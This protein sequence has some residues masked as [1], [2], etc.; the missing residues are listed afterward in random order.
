MKHIFEILDSLILLTILEIKII[1][2]FKTKVQ[3]NK[4]KLKYLKINFK[5]FNKQ[6]PKS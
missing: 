5:Y 1:F 6:L 2:D 3:M 4:K